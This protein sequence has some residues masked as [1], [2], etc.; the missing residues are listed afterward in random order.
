M[1][2]DIKVIAVELII[3]LLLTMLLC[4]FY[5]IFPKI[6]CI[7][8]AVSDFV[9]SVNSLNVG[10]IFAA[11]LS[12][13]T[14]GSRNMNDIKKHKSFLQ[15]V[16]IIIINSLFLACLPIIVSDDYQVK[17]AIV[18]SALVFTISSLIQVWRMIKL[19][20]DRNIR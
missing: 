8:F 7:S 1:K 19:S 5:D 15:P 14:S 12:V 20:L 18:T 11:F 4:Y 10:L 3:I 6:D 2:Y 9:N 13:F 16:K 17:L